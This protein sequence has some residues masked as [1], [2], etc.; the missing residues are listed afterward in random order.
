MQY[1]NQPPAAPPCSFPLTDPVT[2]R[3]FD[4]EPLLDQID[5]LGFDRFDF[6]DFGNWLDQLAAK[7]LIGIQP[8][9]SYQVRNLLEVHSALNALARGFRGQRVHPYIRASSRT[10]RENEEYYAEVAAKGIT[11]T[12]DHFRNW[13]FTR[14][15]QPGYE[16]IY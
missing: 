9:E 15:Q 10:Q 12:L 4:L 3:T 7:S 5:N 2:G 13:I 11:P 8:G 14:K 6:E 16:A 1:T